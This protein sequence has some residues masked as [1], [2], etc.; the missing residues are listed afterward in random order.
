MIKE[1]LGMYIVLYFFNKHPTS[2]PQRK[3]EVHKRSIIFSLA[4]NL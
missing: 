4:H 1:K 3:T 2:N